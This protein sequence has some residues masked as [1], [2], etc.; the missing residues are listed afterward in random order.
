MV[1]VIGHGSLI[2]E[3]PLPRDFLRGTIV[4]GIS[5]DDRFVYDQYGNQ[6]FQGF[7]GGS[8]NNGEFYRNLIAK[9]ETSRIGGGSTQ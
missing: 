8:P 4:R 5:E 3:M 7:G 2:L 6:V 9:W 1:Q